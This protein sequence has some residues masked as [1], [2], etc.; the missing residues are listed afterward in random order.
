MSKIIQTRIS[1]KHS[2]EKDWKEHAKTFVPMLGEII[3]YE[4]EVD[5]DGT[6]K[7]LPEG[8]TK[9]YDYAR[10]KIGDGQRF[11]GDL[12]FLNE[13]ITDAEIDEIC[14]TDISQLDAA[15]DEII[16]LQNSYIEMEVS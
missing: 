5:S 16:E 12:P 15:I 1:Q 6:I 10:I 4:T 2:L 3:V 9:P 7:A 13:A 8:R 14:Q 11:V